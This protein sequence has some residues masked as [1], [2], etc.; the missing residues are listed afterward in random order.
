LVIRQSLPFSPFDA[1]RG[2]GVSP[3]ATIAIGV[4]LAVHLAAGAYV[5]LQR[6]VAPPP[7]AVVEDPPINAPIVTLA[8]PKDAAPSPSRPPDTVNPRAPVDPIGDPRPLPVPPMP[9]AMPD[10]GPTGTFGPPAVPMPPL[11]PAPPSPIRPDWL[12][13]PGPDEFA[14]FY[15]ESA[16]R[17]GVQGGATLGCAVTARGGV[18]GCRVLVESPAGEGFGDAALKL[19]RFFRMKPQ[20]EDG[21]PVDGAHVRIPIRFTLGG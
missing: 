6:F 21:R 2:R 15:P 20:T 19:S 4:S 12:K 7:A 5:A 10:P 9:D 13:K 17:R 11:P 3:S 1:P 18:A 14:R 8:P 16:L